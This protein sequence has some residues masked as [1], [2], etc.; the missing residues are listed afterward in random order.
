MSK[1]LYLECYSGISGDMTVAAL[2]DLGADREV[3]KE[4]LK[5]LPVG[6]FRTEITRVKK[7]GL[8]ACDFSVILEQDN[9]DHDMEYLHGSEKSY[10]GHYEHS[11]EV[12]HEHHHGHTHSHEHPHEHRGMKE[13]TEIIQKSEM[14][15]RAKKMAMRVFDILAQ[16][17]SKAHGVP[18]E[19]VHFHEVGAVDSIVDIA[20]I[21][22][23]MDNLDISNV[24][25]P[26]LYEGTGFI[27]CQHGQIPVPVPAVTHIA[28]THKLK[29]KITDIQGEL[30]TPTGAAVVAAFRTSDRLPEDFTM[31]KTGIGAGKRQYRCPGILRAMLIRE[32]TD[33]QIKDIIWKLE[34]D[35]DDCGGEMMGHVMNLLM[36]NG[37]REVH[38]TPIYTKKNRPAYTLT[39]ICKESEREKLENL[40]FSETTTIGIRRVEMER[41]ILQR[42]IQK[43]DTPV[44]TAIVKACTL[45]DG[46]IRYYPEYENVA[47]LA[48]R[49]QLSFR[50]TYDRIR[51]YWTTER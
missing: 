9:H 17:E 33:L 41:T 32:T 47:E 22:I 8:D 43:K 37:A 50:E 44:G 30:V 16:A 1:T 4:S 13:I 23:C 28:E 6:G 42:E 46:N 34:T 5:S 20:A 31:L 15:V 49:N 36:A 26:V 27:R 2:L 14:T 48:E 38:Y 35:M 7:S 51:S 40:I 19:E 18:V 11:H 21:A 29:L 24:I 3:L 25:V 10:T 39:V 12:N 45:P